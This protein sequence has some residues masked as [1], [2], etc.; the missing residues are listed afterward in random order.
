[1]VLDSPFCNLRQL[2]SELAQSEYL[3]VKVP[4]WLLSGALAMGRMRIKSLCNF[5][6]DQL[7]PEEHVGNSFIPALFLHGIADD[8][9][10][11]HHTQTLFDAYNGD[12]ELEFVEGD[13]N[14]PREM[15]VI[16]KAVMFFCRALRCNPAPASARSMA[17]RLGFD[18]AS[19]DAELNKRVLNGQVLFDAAKQFAQAALKGARSR[20]AEVFRSSL[21]CR[22]EGTLLL[23]DKTVRAGYCMGILPLPTEY[24]VNRP[25]LV[26]FCLI[27]HS[28][29]EVWRSTEGREP[30]VLTRVETQLELGIPLLFIVDLALPTSEPSYY[31][32]VRA[33]ILKLRLGSGGAEIHYP[34]SEEFEHSMFVW[35]VTHGGNAE[36]FDTV[37]KDLDLPGSQEEEPACITPP[38]AAAQPAETESG[39]SCR[40]S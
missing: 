22:T 13:H 24:G 17:Q 18:A 25:P 8:F 29:M 23:Q 10:A 27:S 7:A 14:S 9:I 15:Q 20:L 28:S 19:V 4:S 11:P 3:S 21:P 39:S 2:A 40:Q 33:P 34:L 36:F 5:D 37:M 12:K 6:I 30:E 16:R 1:M 35:P 38:A 26:L 31:G 32:P